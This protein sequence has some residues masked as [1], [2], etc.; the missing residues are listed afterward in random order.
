[1][2]SWKTVVQ[3]RADIL[4]NITAAPVRAKSGCIIKKPRSCLEEC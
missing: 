1:M 2:A 3:T 4:S